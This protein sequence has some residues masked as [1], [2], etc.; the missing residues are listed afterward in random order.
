MSRVV[1]VEMYFWSKCVDRAYGS[2]ATLEEM[3]FP[4]GPLTLLAGFLLVW[5]EWG[6]QEACAKRP[7]RSLYTPIKTVV[8][9]DRERCSLSPS[10]DFRPD[11]SS[12]ASLP[13][14]GNSNI[15]GTSTKR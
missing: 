2:L 7:T 6:R 13:Q 8:R 4:P 14:Q 5:R 1:G 3:E 12:G 15:S 9:V 10:S 11:R